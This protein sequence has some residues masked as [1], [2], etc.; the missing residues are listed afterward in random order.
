MKYD[1]KGGIFL[2]S[3]DEKFK[4]AW[5]Y[6]DKRYSLFSSD[7]LSKIQV[8]S[9]NNAIKEW[10]NICDSEIFQTS[11][12]IN[13]IIN[14]NISVYIG[15]CKWGEDE[16]ETEKELLKLFNEYRAEAVSL[17]YDRDTALYVSAELFCKKWSDFCYPSDSILIIFDAKII[18]YYEDTIYG[19]VNR[20]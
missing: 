6:M 7:E 20:L 5:R 2:E 11:S 14:S 17:F 9:R 19:P 8:I 13:K 4:Y 16:S 1:A 3:I 15:N 10:D 12:Y 18:I